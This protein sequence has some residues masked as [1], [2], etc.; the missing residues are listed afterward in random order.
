MPWRAAAAARHGTAHCAPGTLR[1]A[2]VDVVLRANMVGICWS[3]VLV[4][5]VFLLPFCSRGGF[6]VL[7]SDLLMK[8]ALKSEDSGLLFIEVFVMENNSSPK[9][10]IFASKSR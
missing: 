5:A 2:A 9:D 1:P 10:P 6:T 8:F 4:N 3:L 7:F